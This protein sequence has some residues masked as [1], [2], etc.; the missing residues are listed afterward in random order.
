MAGAGGTRPDRT[1]TH[2]GAPAAEPIRSA[3]ETDHRRSAAC[4]HGARHFSTRSPAD[5]HESRPTLTG[6][7]GGLMHLDELRGIGLFSG[8]ADDQLHALLAA[9]TDLRLAGGDTLFLESPAAEFWWV[10]LEGS[11]DLVRHVGREETRLG[12]MDVPGRWAGGF[13]AWD[14]H[15]VY[16]ATGRAATAGRVLRVPAEALRTLWTTQFPLGLYLIEGV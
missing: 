9:G 14:E 1:T 15:G 16:L 2:F 11:I 10:L 13:R 3:H 7:P 5:G 12:V 4:F 6:W 8:T